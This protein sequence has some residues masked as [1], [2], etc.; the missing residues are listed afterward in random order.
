MAD[1][2]GEASRIKQR[3]FI[4][5]LVSL[6]G[7]I[8]KYK[9]VNSNLTDTTFSNIKIK[10]MKSLTGKYFIV[11]VRY[12]KTLEDGT[13]AKTTEQ[14][15]VD[16]LSWSE[17]EAKTTEEMAKY[18]NSDIE[19]VTMKKA[20]FSEL[21]LSG[22]DSEDKYY[23]CSIN[24]ITIDDKSDKEKKTKVRYLV[25]GDTIEKARK[26][27]DEIMGKSLI[28]YDITSLKETSIMDVFLHMGKPKE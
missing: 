3:V 1:T 17:C 15:V 14:Y 25:Q 13:N 20:G 11:G 16:A 27:V 21:F 7:W 2:S 12:E 19:I 8:D 23:D 6:L 4:G 18:T 5:C 28:D 24:M 26:N 22:V 9:V 10:D